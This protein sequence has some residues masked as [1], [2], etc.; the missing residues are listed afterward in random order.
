MSDLRNFLI[1]NGTLVACRWAGGAVEVPAGVTAIGKGA[2]ADIVGLTAV[3]LPDGLRRVGDYA[4]SGCTGLT[5][6]N[7]PEGLEEIGNGAFSGCG[8]LTGVTLPKSLKKI[9]REAF[10]DCA[11]LTEITVA[12]GNRVFR[13][14]NGLLIRRREVLCW[15][16]GR[17]GAAQVPE[18]VQKIARLA[19]ADCRGV[20]EIYLPDSVLEIGG[21]AF[22]RC[23]NLRRLRLSRGLVRIGSGMASGCA[24]LTE[25][26]L[27]GTLTDIGE[28]T[29][30]RS[31]L[32]SLTIPAGV[33]MVRRR[34]FADCAGLREVTVAGDTELTYEVFARSGVETLRLQGGKVVS[35]TFEGCDRLTTVY[36]RQPIAA[37][38]KGEVKD[39]ALLTAVRRIT[40]G[41]ERPEE[42]LRYIK[43]QRKHL[44]PLAVRRPELL[45]L[46][47][48]EG[49]L[50]PRDYPL[51]LAEA[52]AQSDTAAKAAILE[53]QNRAGGPPDPFEEMEEEVRKAERIAAYIEK[54]GV[55]PVSE[56]K[57]LWSWRKEPDGT[58]TVTS[59]KGEEAEITVPDAIGK[60]PVAAIEGAFG[61]YTAASEKYMAVRRAI[62]RV[63]L[64]ASLKRIGAY[65]FSGCG[66]LCSVEIPEG[67]TAIG[68]GAFQGCKS[69][70]H[71]TLPTLLREIGDSAFARCAGLA[72]ITIPEGVTVLPHDAFD[73]CQKLA[74]VTLPDSLREIGYSA[75]YRCAAL[76]SIVIPDGVTAIDG[77]AFLECA[78]LIRVV[79]P[80]SLTALS[81][82][83]FMSC[84]AL[85]WLAVPAG[86]T[87]VGRWAF[88]NCRSLERVTLPGSVTDIA[89]NA[90]DHNTPALTIQ[91]PAGSAAAEY[92]R[93]FRIKF[94]PMEETAP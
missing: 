40:A 35:S 26:D 70:R 77:R 44:F 74:D 75:F 89:D 85:R 41:E 72:A 94:T 5:E 30:S 8:A 71:L 7:L 50:T 56:L 13:F 25:I 51:L 48:T 65:S 17:G 82:S 43:N 84:Y 68:R 31:G 3:R 59:Y 88:H 18:G 38:P 91:A 28:Y 14:E 53:Y 86:V 76:R 36:A 10:R 90:F 20:T 67:V 79:L 42:V 64:P 23:V 93:K 57:K 27:P 21:E 15:P 92:A 16:M 54:N 58:L 73:E 37:L 69:L 80:A 22:A 39:A 49:M 32:T 9:G 63:T 55:L 52:E 4:F 24:A 83:T 78:A 6:V 34:A 46:M 2:F 87:E 61:L 11:R 66:Q 45:R 33:T 1:E 29:F 60:S 81:Y 62:R 12:E 19:F 47:V